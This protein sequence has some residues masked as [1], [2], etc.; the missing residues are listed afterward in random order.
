MSYSHIYICYSYITKS[1]L[2]SATAMN[3]VK[4]IL[5]ERLASEV[6]SCVKMIVYKTNLE[7]VRVWLQVFVLGISMDTGRTEAGGKFWIGSR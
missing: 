2:A 6:A 5:T 7:I 1:A 3:A 4:D